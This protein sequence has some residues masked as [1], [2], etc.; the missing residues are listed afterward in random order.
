MTCLV[1]RRASY[2][3]LA[4]FLADFFVAFFAVFFAAAMEMA[5]CLWASVSPKRHNSGRIF[6]KCR[7]QSIVLAKNF[8][9]SSH[10]QLA[11]ELPWI[12]VELHSHH[13]SRWLDSPIESGR[14]MF[15]QVEKCQPEQSFFWGRGGGRI[16][17]GR[18]AIVGAVRRS[19]KRR[20][21]MG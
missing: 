19:A 3:F 7:V 2:F 18:V 12:L 8:R 15:R 16:V 6:E 10:L 17:C 20:A 11:S 9:K 14:G 21:M 1:V 4:V 5:P 13:C